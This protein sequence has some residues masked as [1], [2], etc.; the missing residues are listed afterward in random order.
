MTNQNTFDEIAAKIVSISEANTLNPTIEDC[1]LKILQNFGLIAVSVKMDKK[2]QRD[3]VR[4]LIGTI[5]VQTI[6]QAKASNG[7]AAEAYKLTEGKVLPFGGAVTALMQSTYC[8]YRV[9]AASHDLEKM[10][11][12]ENPMTEEQFQAISHERAESLANLYK[13]LRTLAMDFDL[14]LE[15]CLQRGFKK[16]FKE[17]TK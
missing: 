15:E 2:M 9:H 13:A 11:Q 17:Y 8:Q 4:L 5:L 3:H 1:S 12:G 7:I 16:Y 6:L 10:V 14:D